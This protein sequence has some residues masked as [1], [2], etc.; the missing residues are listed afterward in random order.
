MKVALFDFD[1]T[2]Y[3][4]ETFDILIEKIKKHPEYKTVYTKFIRSFG[5][6]YIG[7]KLKLVSRLTMQNKALEKY[8]HSF[9]GMYKEE[10]E[11]FFH[12]IANNMIEDMRPGLVE[13][14][15]KLKEDNYYIVLVSGAFMPL[16][17]ALFKS[18]SVDYIFGS[19]IH[20][21]EGKLDHKKQFN[22]VHSGMKVKLLMD[23]FNSRGDT[24]DWENSLAFSDSYSDIQMLEL[25]GNPVAVQP[26]EKLLKI[27]T[28]KNWKIYN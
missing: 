28:E 18:D 16:L 6:T 7:Y 25:V 24:V 10:I 23:Y 5:P 27:A 13:Q 12:E 22:R 17:E 3:P 14:L 9:K 11:S 21:D 1:G 8:I 26:D 4:H 19:V 20:Y 2:L 15:R